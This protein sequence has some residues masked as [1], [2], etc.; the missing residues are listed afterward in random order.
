[1]RAF[2]LDTNIASSLFDQRHKNHEKVRAFL[3]GQNDHVSISVVT[4]AE[5]RYGHELWP[6]PTH[7]KR[8]ETI[9]NKMREYKVWS[10][11]RHVAEHYARIRAHL[12]QKFASLNAKGKYREK[13]PEDLLNKTT[14]SELQIDENDLW[15]VAQAATNKV[16]LVTTDRMTRLR[17]VVKELYSDFV[18]WN[19]LDCN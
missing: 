15:I 10:I 11:D 17:E 14:G 5:I 1:M 6:N 8:R 7:Q 2:L 18:W 4:L 13:H 3:S 19:P 9:E 16:D 12:F